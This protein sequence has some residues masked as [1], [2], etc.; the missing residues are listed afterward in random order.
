[1]AAYEAHGPG[2]NPKHIGF[3]GFCFTLVRHHALQ[4]SQPNI[5]V[6]EN[7]G[8]VFERVLTALHHLLGRATQHDVANHHHTNQ[9]LLGLRMCGLGT[10]DRPSKKQPCQQHGPTGFEAMQANTL[11]PNQDL[12]GASLCKAQR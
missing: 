3:V 8:K 5:G 10:P 9:G 11:C 4:I 1:M 6:F 7:L 2:M 12:H